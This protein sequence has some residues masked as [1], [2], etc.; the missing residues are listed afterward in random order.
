MGWGDR[1][2][3]VVGKQFTEP[4]DGMR[5]DAREHI[6]ELGKRLDA[7][8]LAERDEGSQHGRRFATSIAAEKGPVAAPERNGIALM[9]NCYSF[10]LKN[11]FTSRCW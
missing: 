11:A 7:A 1:E 5:R 10:R 4:G 2:R 9:Y 8:A 6:A 3:P